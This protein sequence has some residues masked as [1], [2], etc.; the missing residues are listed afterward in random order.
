[1]SSHKYSLFTEK[2]YQLTKKY[3]IPKTYLGLGWYAAY[4]NF[5]ESNW[6]IGYGSEIINDHTLSATDKASQE[7]IDKQFYKDLKFFSKEAEKYIFVNLNKNKRAALLSFAHSIGLCSFKSKKNCLSM[8]SWVA[9]SF[10][11]NAW[12]L[13]SVLPYPNFQDSSQKSL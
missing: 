4:K 9:L 12:P 13:S 8:S 10:A 7:E 6:K 5:G 11:V 2:G 3:T 1:M